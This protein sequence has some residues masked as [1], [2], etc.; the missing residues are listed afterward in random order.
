MS[1][2][3]T[4]GGWPWAGI[5]PAAWMNAWWSRLGLAPQNLV[6]P[7]LSGWAITINGIN[8]SAPQ[9]E[10]EV[11]Q[12]HSYGRQLGRMADALQALID[13]RGQGAPA[14]PRFAE[15]TEMKREIDKLKHD[16]AAA[17]VERLRADL[18]ELKAARPAE[19]RRLRDALRRALDDD[20]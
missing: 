2:G 6:Q 13:E 7:I 12:R 9:T 18:A 19:Y 11:V 17:R 3:S 10:V 1:T 16:A 20:G 15:F 14:N 5:D 4:G 8:S